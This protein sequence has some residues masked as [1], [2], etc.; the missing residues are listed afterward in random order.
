MS[1]TT[2]EL[3]KLITGVRI[4][5][6]A[7]L[8]GLLYLAVQSEIQ[9]VWGMTWDDRIKLAKDAASQ[10]AEKGDILQYG[11]GKKGEVAKAFAAMARGLAAAAFV[12]GG[13]TFQG[14]RY[15]ACEGCGRCHMSEAE[16][17]RDCLRRCP[18][19]RYRMVPKKKK[20]KKLLPKMKRVRS[21]FPLPFGCEPLEGGKS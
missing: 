10:I 14:E 16:R 4:P 2:E 17:I 1:E 21:F 19:C 8:P 6:S 13:I 7:F 5:K 18:N 3:L 11:G 12:P 15:Q 9:W 20:K